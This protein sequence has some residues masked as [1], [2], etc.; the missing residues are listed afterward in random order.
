M[1]GKRMEEYRIVPAE[2]RYC[3]G[4][5]RV[6]SFVAQ[7]GKYLSTNKGFTDEEILNFFHYCHTK[8]F[9]QLFVVDKNDEVIGWCDVVPREGYPS[10]VGFIGLGLMPEYRDRGIGG[11]LMERA[12]EESRYAGFRELRLDCRVSNKRAI[13]LYRKLGF[14]RIACLH[15]G[16]IIDNEKIPIVC[17]KKKI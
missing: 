8:G 9:P 5:T 10:S 12:I 13:H 4:H 6:L 11:E 3:G 2:E 16:L 14:R 1:E 7:E 15:S 17:M